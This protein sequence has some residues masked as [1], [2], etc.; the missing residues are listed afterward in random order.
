M[1]K[2]ANQLF[3]ALNGNN[4]QNMNPMQQLIADAKNLQKTFNGN[5]KQMVEELVKSGRMSQDQFNQ[6]AQIANQIVGSGAFK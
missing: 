3:S 5:P 1:Q 2:M 6:Y 4:R